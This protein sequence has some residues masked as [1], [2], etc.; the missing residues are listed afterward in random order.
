M[1]AVPWPLITHFQ[2]ASPTSPFTLSRFP[3]HVLIIGPNWWA[4]SRLY[5]MT[6]IGI[7]AIKDLTNEGEWW[8]PA[9]DVW[10][11][12][13]L[14]SGLMPITV[15]HNGLPELSSQNFK[16]RTVIK[17]SKSDFLIRMSV[18]RLWKTAL[19]SRKWL[20]NTNCKKTLRAIVSVFF[21]RSC[22][23]W[24]YVLFL[25]NLMK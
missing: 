2:V 22:V 25:M 9:T 23:A 24:W 12:N 5:S 15:S 19:K 16:M 10:K 8:F 6:Q 11:L 21:H 7:K 18:W 3:Y 1:C 13:H 17:K 14:A 20:L 4:W